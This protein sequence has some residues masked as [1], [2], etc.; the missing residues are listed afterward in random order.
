[1]QKSREYHWANREKI[2]ERKKM[3]YYE[4]R[5][6]EI[7]CNNIMSESMNQQ[8]EKQAYKPKGKLPIRAAWRYKPDGSYYK[9]VKDT[10]YF[11]DYYNNNI[12]GQRVVCEICKANISAGYRYRH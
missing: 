2:L 6:K 4:K 3:R 12:K 11:T 9:G 5:P 7:K 8:E 10:A 1:M